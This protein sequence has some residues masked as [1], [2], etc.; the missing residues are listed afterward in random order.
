MQKTYCLKLGPQ[1]T[2][3]LSLLLGTANIQRLVLDVDQMWVLFS[4]QGV[5]GLLGGF[6]VLEV[7]E[8][9]TLAL[10]RLIGHNSS[11]GNSTELA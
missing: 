1:F 8:T 2:L 10:A 7:D 3:T 5:N 9:E 11:I 4:I 6:R